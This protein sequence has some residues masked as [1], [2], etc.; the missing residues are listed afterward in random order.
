V[1][2]VRDL[3]A[4]L[5]KAQRPSTGRRSRLAFF[6]KDVLDAMQGIE[7]NFLK[8]NSPL[9]VSVNQAGCLA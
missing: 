5:M 8:S 6:R 3:S 9:S 7:V 2:F 4:I 1:E